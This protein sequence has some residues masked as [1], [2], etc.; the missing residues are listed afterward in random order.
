MSCRGHRWSRAK[1]R[2]R[3]GALLLVLVLT[4]AMTGFAIGLGTLSRMSHQEARTAKEVLRARLASEAGLAQGVASLLSGGVGTVGS[5]QTPQALGEAEVYVTVSDMGGGLTALSSTSVVDGRSA[6]TELVVREVQSSFWAYGA[7]GD[8][9]MT[10]DSNAHVDS[11]DSSLGTYA[12][13]AIFSEGNSVWALTNGHIGSNGPITLDAS[14]S[15]KGNASSG[16]GETVSVLKNATVSGSTTPMSTTKSLDPLTIPSIASSGS[17]AV[18][19][20][21]AHTLAAGDYR[22]DD[23]LLHSGSDLLVVGPA[24]IVARSAVLGSNSSWQVDATNGPVEIYV[25]DDFV[26]NSNTTIASLD[27]SPLDIQLYLESDNVIDPNLYVDLD[28]VDLD[29]N[30]SFYGTIYAPN[31]NIE[32]NSNFELFGAIVAYDLHLDSNSKIH[33]DEALLD[34]DENAKL[35]LETVCWR[36]VPVE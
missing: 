6:R 26:M 12:S 10:M 16:P 13:Q 22:F 2:E 33:F 9:E 36:E 29:S 25:E 21:G 34:Q 15:V 17:L 7:F 23:L 35:V 3:G 27:Q 20:N 18:P 30:A 11:Y 14:S 24:T 32:I 28:Y 1:E 31:A 19:K 5:V 8:L 4:T